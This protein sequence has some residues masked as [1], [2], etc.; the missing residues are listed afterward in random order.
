VDEK[1][2]WIESVTILNKTLANI[3]GDI[4]IAAGFL[5]YLGLFTVSMPLDVTQYFSVLNLF[6]INQL[7]YLSFYA[8]PKP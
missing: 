3:V 7:S 4:L 6:L 5:A 8:M 1:D 2:R